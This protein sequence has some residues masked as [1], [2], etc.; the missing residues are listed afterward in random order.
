MLSVLGYR[1]DIRIDIMSFRFWGYR[2]DIYVMTLYAFGF[3]GYRSDI[4]V[5]TLLAFGFGAIK[6]IYS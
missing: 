5:M 6:V 3:W 1:S 4:Y 2:S